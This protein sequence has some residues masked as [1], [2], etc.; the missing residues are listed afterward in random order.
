MLTSSWGVCDYILPLLGGEAT[1]GQFWG[2]PVVC[3]HQNGCN[4]YR[5][6]REVGTERDAC[7][8]EDGERNLRK[9]GHGDAVGKGLE[10]IGTTIQRAHSQHMPYL[11][12]T[13]QSCLN[14]RDRRAY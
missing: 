5:N 8:S 14:N 10:Q 9:W 11:H 1:M 4:R 13:V 6:K 7:A 12:A 2:Y 3:V